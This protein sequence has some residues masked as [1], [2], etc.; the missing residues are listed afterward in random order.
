METLFKI[1]A[2]NLSYLNER[3]EKLNRKAAKLGVAPV[4]TKVLATSYHKREAWYEI[5]VT[6]LAPKLE[7]GWTFLGTLEHTEAGNILRA[8]P[9]QSIPEQYRTSPK[10][11]DHC[12]TIRNRKDTYV[13]KSEA[14]ETKQVGHNCVRDY[15]GHT[16]PARIA[17]LAELIREFQEAGNEGS[18]RI[19]NEL[20][21]TAFME[22]AAEVV[23]RKGF[24][25]AKAA[26]AYAEKSGG[27][28]GLTTTAAEV[29]FQFFHDPKLEREHPEW[30][31]SVTEAGVILGGDALDYAKTLEAKSDYEY[32][33]RTIAQKVIITRRDAGLL[34]SA[35]GAYQ[36]HMGFQA[37]RKAKEAKFANSQYFGTVGKREIFGVTV[38]GEH[39]FAPTEYGYGQ[40]NRV[41]YRMQDAA[42]N[43]AVWFT[44]GKKLEVG[45]TYQLK[46][47]VK[48]HDDYK[49]IKQTVLT[50]AAVT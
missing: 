41:L 15:L 22:M 30:F 31:F 7:G 48:K 29:W 43:V 9:G 46:A 21:M 3:L 33:L 26:Q 50:R 14:G 23:L 25:S 32:N 45:K 47:T 11:C 42:G 28:A 5:E 2:R 24:V 36:K 1:P 35:I 49:G 44:S 19:P 38:I 37:E 18:G 16:S 12:K 40:E 6:G 4:S 10:T 13:V 27:V 39:I 17:L 34:A 8:L 20:S